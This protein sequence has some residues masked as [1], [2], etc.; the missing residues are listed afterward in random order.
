MMEGGLKL[1]DLE[2]TLFILDFSDVSSQ[3]PFGHALSIPDHVVDRL[4]DP[5]RE[6][7][8]ACNGNDNDNDETN[9]GCPDRERDFLFV[10]FKY[11][12]VPLVG[13]DVQ[14]VEV[15]QRT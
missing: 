11:A 5:S 13:F 14:E 7:R 3:I 1:I 10:G 9:H 2:L 12:V 4:G 8:R 15:I 6:D